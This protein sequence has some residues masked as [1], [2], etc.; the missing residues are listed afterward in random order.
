LA[1]HE[2]FSPLL[3]VAAVL[4]AASP[5]PATRAPLTAAQI[6]SIDAFVTTEMARSKGANSM[7]ITYGLDARGKVDTLYFEPDQEYR[8]Q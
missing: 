7:L 6:S 1:F 3:F 5:P 4:T 2:V 8:S